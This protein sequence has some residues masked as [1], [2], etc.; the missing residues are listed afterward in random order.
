MF[1][2]Q[3]SDA[4]TTCR[5]NSARLLT[6]S[7]VTTHVLHDIWLTEKWEL[8]MQQLRDSD[9]LFSFKLPRIYSGMMFD[10]TNW[11]EE[12]TNNV[13]DVLPWCTLN[14]TSKSKPRH[15]IH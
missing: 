2:G 13:S 9:M 8:Q 7:I 4:S 11:I 6:P 1:Y 14:P 5:N 12:G 10:G 15:F 3:V